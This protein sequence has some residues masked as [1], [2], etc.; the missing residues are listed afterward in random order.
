MSTPVAIQVVTTCSSREEAERLASVVINEHLA[1]CAQLEPIL[2]LY[3]WNSAVQR[4]AEVRISFKTRTALFDTLAARIRGLSSYQTPQIIAL[5]IVAADSA[6]LDW[7][8][9]CTR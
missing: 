3:H 1:A 2:S 6:Y 5:P 7:I 4:D 8:K 9:D